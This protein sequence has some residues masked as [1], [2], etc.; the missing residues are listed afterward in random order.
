MPAGDQEEEDDND[1]EEDSQPGPRR[2]DEGGH[3]APER[4]WGGSSLCSRGQSLNF[5]L[6]LFS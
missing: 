6:F 5:F 3:E 1:E 2:K 4:G